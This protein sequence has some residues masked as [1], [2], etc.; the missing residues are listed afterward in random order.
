MEERSGYSHN[1]RPRICPWT[2]WWV[3]AAPKAQWFLGVVACA[4][5]STAPAVGTRKLSI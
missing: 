1:Q 3:A 5:D 2:T 4:G